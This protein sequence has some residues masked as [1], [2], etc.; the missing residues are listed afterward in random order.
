MSSEEIGDLLMAVWRRWKSA[1]P[2]GR[3]AIT[4]EQ[5]WVLKTLRERGPMKVKDLASIV[6]CTAGSASVAV[7][8]LEKA[9]L[10]KRERNDDD[11]RVVTITLGKEG[12]EKLDAW[13]AEQF[14]SMVMLF[15]LLSRA[16]RKT[17]RDL[18]EK[19]LGFGSDLPMLSAKV[20]GGRS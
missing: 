15:E 12:I 13:R 9:G 20:A 2:V 5:Y 3:G 7:K 6:G 14:K 17:L 19:A 10:V 1:S 8:R 11:E 18:L 16:E 4:Q